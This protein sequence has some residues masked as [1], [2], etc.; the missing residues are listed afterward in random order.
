M[1]SANRDSFTSSFLMWMLLLLLFDC[2]GRTF[3]CYIEQEWWE[4]APVL[5]LILEKKFQPITIKY[6][7]SSGLV[8]YMALIMLRYNSCNLLRIFIKCKCWICLTHF[9]CIYWNMRVFFCSVNVVYYINWFTCIEPSLHSSYKSH[10]IM[11]NVPF[12]VLLTLVC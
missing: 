4:W 11:S 6:H 1:S 10:L 12:T 3:Q 5:F 9:S 7:V 2:S 8:I